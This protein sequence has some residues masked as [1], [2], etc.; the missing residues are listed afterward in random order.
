MSS[1]PTCKKTF[2]KSGKGLTYRYNTIQWVPNPE[3]PGQ[4]EM[5]LYKPFF[6]V[7]FCLQ[8]AG[9][10]PPNDIPIAPPA[11]Q[12]AYCNTIIPGSL[13]TTFKGMALANAIMYPYLD[14]GNVAYVPVANYE[15]ADY[16]YYC[17]KYFGPNESDFDTTFYVMGNNLA[18]FIS[19]LSEV[20]KYWAFHAGDASLNMGDLLDFSDLIF[21]GMDK[22][23]FLPP[24]KYQVYNTGD[25]GSV[26]EIMQN[27]YDQTGG[28]YPTYFGLELN[29]YQ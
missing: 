16:S 26:G 11:E 10:I 12:N 18:S 20:Q 21:K 24:G 15:P 27:F 22:R 19:S 4:L 7:A 8:E 17:G 9:P 1:L 3:Q 23:L 25:A 2:F 5:I 13:V 14:D 29:Q 6:P 28:F